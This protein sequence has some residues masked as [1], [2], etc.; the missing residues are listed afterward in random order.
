LTPARAA[1]SSTLAPANP[2][3]A[4]SRRAAVSSFFRVAAGSRRCGFVS[5]DRLLGISNQTVDNSR[6]ALLHW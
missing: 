5:S 1:I 3:L 6:R 2:L 4:N